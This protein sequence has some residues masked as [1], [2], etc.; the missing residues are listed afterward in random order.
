MHHSSQ[1]CLKNCCLQTVQCPTCAL[2]RYLAFRVVH[3]PYLEEENLHLASCLQ[4]DP[5]L[6]DVQLVLLTDGKTSFAAFLHERSNGPNLGFIQ[7]GFNAGDGNR[8]ANVP[9][10][11]QRAV[12]I[13]RID[14]NKNI[15][16][17][18]LF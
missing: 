4:A 14:G 2:K 3:V 8:L 10:T 16:M 17:Y 5:Y 15:P 12:N 6:L 18:Y 7:I 1:L 11:S 13:F 9:G